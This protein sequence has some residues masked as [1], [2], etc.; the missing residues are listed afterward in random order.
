MLSIIRSELP[1]IAGLATLVLLWTVGSGLLADLANPIVAPLVFLWIFAVMVWGAF[2]VVSHADALADLLGEPLGTLVLTLS[3]VGIEVSLI[4]AIMLAGEGAPT[5]ARDTMFAVLMIVL[6]GMVGAALLVGGF[7]HREQTFNLQGAQA[8]LAVLVPLSVVI[9]ILPNFTI[10]TPD[11]TLSPLQA[12]LFALFTLALYAVFLAIQTVR[13]RSFFVQPG[14]DV[15]VESRADAIHRDR[16]AITRTPIY[17][18]LF[19]VLTLVPIVLLSHDLAILV[20]F[21]IETLGA[22]AALGGILIA[23]LI[24]APEAVSALNAARANHL[25]RSV[26]IC[27]GASLS[28]IGM[29]VPAVLVVSLVTGQELLLGLSQVG[30]LLLFL[31]LLVCIMTFGGRRTNML[32]GAVHIVLFLVFLVLT[33]AP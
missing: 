22:P 4:T 9:L 3:I 10:S 1:F 18:A 28:T 19:L 5:L 33:I 17:H 20:D 24:L 21:G 14:T 23:S 12:T 13:H 2:S 7:R 15:T 6:N 29:T 26:N 25:Q 31:T 32:Q 27:L 30:M 16:P 8:F 11:P